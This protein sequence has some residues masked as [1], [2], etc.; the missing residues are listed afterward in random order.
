MSRLTIWVNSTE[1]LVGEVVNTVQF[2][3]VLI[4]R[5]RGLKRVGFV[6]G[7]DDGCDDG[8]DDGDTPNDV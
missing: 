5:S 8:C 3:A 7:F 2:L 4:S 6:D 1:I